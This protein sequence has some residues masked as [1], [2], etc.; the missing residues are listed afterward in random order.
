MRVDIN[1]RKAG[2]CQALPKGKMILGHGENALKAIGFQMMKGGEDP[3]VAT[4]IG[5]SSATEASGSIKLG[6]CLSS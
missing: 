2:Q 6:I 1:Q 4:P 3:C 5:F